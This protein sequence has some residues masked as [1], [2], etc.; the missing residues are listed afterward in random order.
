MVCSLEQAA[1][2]RMDDFVLNAIYRCSLRKTIK[3]VIVSAEMRSAG[4]LVNW[5]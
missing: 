2:L 4:V 1:Y 3:D 5:L